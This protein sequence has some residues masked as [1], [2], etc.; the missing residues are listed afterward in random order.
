MASVIAT[1]SVEESTSTIIMYTPLRKPI[2]RKSE[3]EEEPPI[4]GTRRVCSIELPIKEPILMEVFNH[5]HNAVFLTNVSLKQSSPTSPPSF[6][7][8]KIKLQSRGEHVSPLFVQV[9]IKLQ[10]L[11]TISSLP[12]ISLP[13][14]TSLWKYFEFSLSPLRFHFIQAFVSG[15]RPFFLYLIQ[16]FTKLRL[17]SIDLHLIISGNIISMGHDSIVKSDM[18]LVSTEDGDPIRRTQLGNISAKI[19]DILPI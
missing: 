17:S 10:H 4:L 18:N 14:T 7:V 8:L 5:T 6:R 3:R 1:L 19:R 11:F 9:L 15:K 13:W 16:F 2:G 12:T